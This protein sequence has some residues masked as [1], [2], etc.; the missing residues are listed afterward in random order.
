M[1]LRIG[2]GEKRRGG[3][4]IDGRKMRLVRKRK[5]R[6]RRRRGGEERR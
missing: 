3:G 4:E 5:G 2:R 6:K 1:E